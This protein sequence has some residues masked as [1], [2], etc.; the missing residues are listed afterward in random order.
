[1]ADLTITAA[2]VDYTSGSGT[3]ENGT[4]GAAVTI[5]QAVYKDQQDSKWKL[6]QNDGTAEEAG[7]GGIAVALTESAADGQPITVAKTGTIDL[8]AT[9]TVGEIYCLSST[10]GGIA[11]EADSA[12]TNDYITILG[13]A[14]AADSLKLAPIVSGA[15]VP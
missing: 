13:V 4:A 14:T 8:G 9:L 3:T 10:A 2:S 1:M 11:P 5:G 12:T 7:A 6:A 15:Q